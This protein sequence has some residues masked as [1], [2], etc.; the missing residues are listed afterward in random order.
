MVSI[1]PWGVPSCT[2]PLRQQELIPTPVDISKAL[3]SR[4]YDRKVAA[5]TIREN[6][7]GS[8]KKNMFLQ[9]ISCGRMLDSR[10]VH[11][12]LSAV[13]LRHLWTSMQLIQRTNAMLLHGG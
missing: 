6:E 9:R 3:P 12:L 10:P 4:K 8:G 1:R 13:R 2:L 11:A 5:K 7:C